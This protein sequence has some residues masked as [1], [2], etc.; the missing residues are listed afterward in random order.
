MSATGR[1]VCSCGDVIRGEAGGVDE[2]GR[3]LCWPCSIERQMAA[4]PEWPAARVGS[5]FFKGCLIGLP[6]ACAFWFGV[7]L[8]CALLR[9]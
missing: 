5:P 9:G 7:G 4:D 2:Q 8:L 6:F 3:P 1:Q